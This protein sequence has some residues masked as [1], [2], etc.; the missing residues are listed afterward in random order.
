MQLWLIK[1]YDITDS[2]SFVETSLLEEIF[3][4]QIFADIVQTVIYKIF[5]MYKHN[6]FDISFFI[7]ARAFRNSLD[8]NSY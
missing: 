1:G 3:E 5:P 7:T 2:K 8:I 6:N 4:L